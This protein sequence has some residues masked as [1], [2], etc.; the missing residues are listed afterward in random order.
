MSGRREGQVKQ[1]QMSTQNEI[2]REGTRNS[3]TFLPA[4]VEKKRVQGV[5]GG[6]YL[7]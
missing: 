7:R 6:S 2:R 1:F 4:G 3:K 5:V